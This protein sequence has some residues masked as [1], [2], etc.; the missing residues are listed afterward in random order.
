MGIGIPWFP[1]SLRPWAKGLRQNNQSGNRPSKAIRAQWG[2][3]LFGGI[4]DQ[5]WTPEILGDRPVDSVSAAIALEAS[6]E[7]ARRAIEG[8]PYFSY[9]GC[10]S[11][12]HWLQI[13][14][15][16]VRKGIDLGLDGFN[17][18]HNLSLIHI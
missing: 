1:S 11:N 12:P 13:L 18:T 9:R 5:M 10:I 7:P 15:A 17:T 8:R 3:G 16:M 6:G 4:W 2:L 14:K